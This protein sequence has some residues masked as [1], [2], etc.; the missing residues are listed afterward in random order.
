MQL[1]VIYEPILR[2]PAAS[3]RV[4]DA[5]LKKTAEQMRRLMKESRGI[6]LAANQ[7]GLNQRLL[8]ME[9]QPKNQGPEQAV[10]RL[11]LANPRL[12]KQSSEKETMIEACLSIPGLEF[13]VTR[14]IG[15]TIE[16]E[17]L[18]GKTIKIKTKGLAAR[19]LQHEIDHLN[20]VLFTDHVAKRELLNLANYQ[21]VKIVFLGSDDFSLE[22]LKAL[23]G[24]GL[25]LI[26]V[27]TETGKKASRGGQIKSTPVKD[28]ALKNNLTCFQPVD[29]AELESIMTQLK[30]DLIVL[31]SY[32][33]II[34][35]SVLALPAFGSINVH[36]SL[37]PRYRGS[38]PIQ[39]AILNGDQV[40]GVTLM[41]M[42]AQIDAGE[43]I[44]QKVLKLTG[45]ET[46][47]EL[48]SQLAKIGAEQLLKNLPLYLA[49]QAKLKVQDDNKVSL[50]EKLTKET[51]QIDWQRPLELIERQIRAYH[52]WPGS[53]TFLH[54]KRLKILSARLDQGQLHLLEVQLEGKQPTNWPDFVRGHLKELKETDWFGKIN[55]NVD[56]QIKT[57][58]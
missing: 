25:N 19:V 47:L 23:A 24:N 35:T 31:A 33:R 3:I 14:P 55:S 40:T 9:Y 50:A 48:R 38:T 26:G 46:N 52:P 28:F 27:V 7:V 45:R 5:K 49:G 41:A 2:T 30:P 18:S 21:P 36:P 56:D 54:N 51:G 44:S 57:H 39:Q 32:G 20:G 6:G 29:S 42:T 43:I 58:R 37:L 53:F 22:S 15:V 10:P 11:E 13:P 16:A 12:V 1:R 17:N 4:F 34:P 8:V